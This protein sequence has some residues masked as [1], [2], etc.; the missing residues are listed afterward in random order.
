MAD[1]TRVLNPSA[2]PG[3]SGDT[4]ATDDIGDV[5]YQRVK[6][7]HGA[8][9]VNDG[10]VSTANPFPVAVMGKTDGGAFYFAPVTQEGHLEVA[11]H[12][13]RLPFGSLDVAELNPQF[14]TDAVYGINSSEVLSFTDGTGGNSTAESNLFSCS[15]GGTNIGYFGALQS[16]KRLRYRAGQGVVARYTALFSTPQANSVMVAGVGTS[17]S[18]FYFGYNGDSFGVLHNT[19]GKREI[20]TLTVSAGA[21]GAE[22]ATVTLGGVATNVSVTSGTA[23]FNAYQISRA[24]YNGWTAAQRGATVIFLANSVGN[25]TGNFTLATSGGGTLAGTFV[26]TLAG[27][28]ATDNWV[29]QAEWNGDK[30]DGN[31]ASGTILNPANGNVYQVDIQYLGF[32]SVV[33][34]VESQVE[35]NNPEWV[36]A[37][38]FRFPNS[39]TNISVTQPSFPFTMSA[40]NVGPTDPAG[41]TV[42]VKCGSFAGFVAGTK[43]LTGPRMSYFNTAGVISSTSAYTPIFTI[44]NDIVYAS[45]A[46]QS[47]VNMLS[48]GGVAKSNTGITSFYI[49]RNATLSAGTPNFTQFSATSSTYIDLAATACTFATNDQVIFTST[50]AGDGSFSI[51]FSD[52]ITLQPGETVTLAVRSVTATAVCVGQINTREDQ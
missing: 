22:T 7:I 13:P 44:R 46:N 40:A 32:G 21:G 6:L 19:G 27:V 24:T 10:D 34:K 45:R 23:T 16:R 12:G 33:M 26:E 4:I 31:G 15:T 38:T 8:D 30:L 37:H 9:G 18:G 5:K 41:G 52:E 17:E 29:A 48:V 42:T 28:A 2:I 1:N 49:I 36:V 50:I 11:V 43:K 25:K 51:A 39:Q 47:V 3:G 14:Q 35:R 20:Q